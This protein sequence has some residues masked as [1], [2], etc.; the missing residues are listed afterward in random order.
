MVATRRAGHLPDSA[1]ILD[2]HRFL[3]A[4]TGDLSFLHL[5][6]RSLYMAECVLVALAIGAWL[7][8]LVVVLLRRS[9]PDLRIGLPVVVAFSVRFFAAA[10]LGSL[11]IAA[12]L[13]GGDETTFVRNAHDL[14]SSSLASS[15]ALDAM[16]STLH[17]WIFSLNFRVFH[18]RPA[19]PDAAR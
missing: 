19:A 4:A 1:P 15:T 5:S 11:S 2:S 8:W 6:D 9:R 16:T 12:Q 14:L 17:T 18:P 13:R 7:L 10:V 3:R